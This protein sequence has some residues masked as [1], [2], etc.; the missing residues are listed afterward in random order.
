MDGAVTYP[1][2]EPS[3]P[4]R[5]DLGWSLRRQGRLASQLRQ[6][7]LF[8]PGFREQ[9]PDRA[10][11]SAATASWFGVGLRGR[12]VTR[13]LPLD[14]LQ[15][16]F[17]QETLR[18][19]LELP[20]SYILIADVNARAVGDDALQVQRVR[21]RVKR[22]LT[23]VCDHLGFPVTVFFASEMCET[24][25][26]E[27][28]S[29]PGPHD[30]LENPYET[31]QLAQ[32]EHMRRKGATLK[33]GWVLA[34]GQRDERHFDTLYMRRYQRPLGFV[35]TR[36]GCSLWKETPRVC[37]YVCERPDHR[38]LLDSNEIISA[39]LHRPG[40]P[41]D[42]VRGYRRLLARLAR[43]HRKL[44]AP[45][46]REDPVDRMQRILCALPRD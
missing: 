11:V 39:K 22:I 13:G 3:P 30:H 35:Y 9:V 45:H 29:V 18:R 6:N 33:V 34:G 12:H 24:R 46:V 28:R 5:R 2:G 20:R 37:P 14:V 16:V 4:L 36:G 44:V 19:S 10:A 15:L 17:A 32:M 38:L 40:A 41:A 25:R 26:F 7:T 21:G 1:A 23:A 43:A 31:L 42:L 8:A 27:P